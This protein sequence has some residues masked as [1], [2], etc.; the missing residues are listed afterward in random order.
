M[1][2]FSIKNFL[3]RNVRYFRNKK[4]IRD[5]K[6]QIR[7]DIRARKRQLTDEEKAEAAKVV[8]ER[9]ETMNAFR[10]AK[11]VFLYWSTSSEL[12]THEYI[13]KWSQN[14]T[15]LL[16]SVSGE[17]MHLRRFVSSKEMKKGDQN[18]M[19]PT[20]DIFKG[21]FDLAIVPGVAFD[22]DRNRMGR[23]RGFY[24]RFLHSKN[25]TVYGVGFDFQV[26]RKLPVTTKDIKMTCVFSPSKTIE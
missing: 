13:R 20:T 22:R 8:F 12:P 17:K 18:I 21:K 7:A 15:I 1:S 26:L 24:D 14:K 4:D 16:P 10:K 2:S 19:E 23:G 25:V 6:C 11:V 9:I 3:E 5:K